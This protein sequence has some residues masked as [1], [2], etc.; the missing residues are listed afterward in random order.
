[1]LHDITYMQNLKS[2]QIVKQEQL[3]IR[4]TNGWLSEGWRVQ[5]GPNR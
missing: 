1:M 4:G 5:G 3:Q 2:K